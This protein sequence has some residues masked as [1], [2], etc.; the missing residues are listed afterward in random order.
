MSSERSAPVIDLAL[1]A[2]PGLTAIVIAAHALAI[3]A[4]AAS[5]LPLWLRICLAT[6]LALLCAYWVLRTGLRLDSRA[7]VR[8]VLYPDD[9]CTLVER[10]GR[11]W[12]ARLASGAVISP[13]LAVVTVRKGYRRWSI[14]ISSGATDGEALREL[15]V[16]LRLAPPGPSISLIGRVRHLMVRGVLQILRSGRGAVHASGRF[17]A[18]ADD[19]RD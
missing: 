5:G 13:G 10:G 1:G 6:G 8:L 9:E 19:D 11:S 18:A 16:R 4:V 14:P 2:A 15:R 12:T 7:L 3:A 17:R